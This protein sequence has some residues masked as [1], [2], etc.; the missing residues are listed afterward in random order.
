MAA[1]SDNQGEAEPISV[2]N[3]DL[4]EE[5]VN[6]WR[7]ARSGAFQTA[8]EEIGRRETWVM[9]DDPPAQAAFRALATVTQ[10]VVP[11]RV[12]RHVVEPEI[13]ECLR[14]AAGYM[15]PARRLLLVY[16]AL[17]VLTW[18]LVSATPELDTPEGRARIY[19]DA[20]SMFMHPDPLAPE[21]AIPVQLDNGEPVGAHAAVI[22]LRTLLRVNAA[23][24]LNEVF[25]PAR[26][27]RVQEALAEVETDY[28]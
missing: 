15:S 22:V 23:G 5:A 16:W 18:T 25:D 11:E 6:A 28:A 19:R 17:D 14:L 2:H 12:A 7:D 24:F 8:L 26:M 3:C 20:A 4:R 10:A 13:L 27:T 9:D 1:S 21:T